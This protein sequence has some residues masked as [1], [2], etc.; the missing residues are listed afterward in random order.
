MPPRARPPFQAAWTPSALVRPVS[1]AGTSAGCRPPGRSHRWTSVPPL[2]R[3][4][5]VLEVLVAPR[6]NRYD[7]TSVKPRSAQRRRSDL[8]TTDVPKMACQII[9]NERQPRG[10]EALQRPR[11]AGDHVRRGVDVGNTSLQR[12]LGVDVCGPPLASRQRVEQAFSGRAASDWAI[13][14]ICLLASPSSV[15]PGSITAP[16]I[17]TSTSS[18]G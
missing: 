3:I 11:I 12:C 14:A 2:Q 1:E 17:G 15:M 4:G 6:L 10:D 9:P 18:R 16:W 8:Y 7:L 5:S 13:R